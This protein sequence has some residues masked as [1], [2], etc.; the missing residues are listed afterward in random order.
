MVVRVA[1]PA[2]NLRDKLSELDKP[3]GLKGSELMR[4]DTV[5]DARDLVSVGRKNMI[6]NGSMAVAQRGSSVSA[7][8]F[9]TPGYPVC[10]RWQFR[11]ENTDHADYDIS[12]PTD[13]PDGICT[14]SLKVD[15]NI[16]ET[17]GLMQMK[18]FG[19]HN[20]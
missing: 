4:S 10:D 17:D 16:A 14:K 11:A 13:A 3:V 7:Q 8:S 5:Q 9:T 6:I 20:Q 1:K 19:L 12:N 15:V 2:F 18:Y